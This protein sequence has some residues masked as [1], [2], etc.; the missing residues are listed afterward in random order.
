MTPELLLLYALTIFSVSIVPGPSMAL[1]FGI[2]VRFPIG[3][4]ASAAMGNVSASLLQGLIA[5]LMLK[6][7]LELSPSVF[8]A[9]KLLGALFIG[10]VGVVFIRDA[11]MIARVDEGD[12]AVPTSS[13]KLFA[14]GFVVAFFNPKAIMFFVALFPMFVG[15]DLGAL[16]VAYVF[17]PIG[18]I[19]LGCFLIYCL[20]GKTSVRLLGPGVVA[21]VVQGL[22][23]ILVITSAT[24]VMMT[25]RDLLAAWG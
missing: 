23:A 1:A 21:R 7:I 22:G 13:V 8:E 9:M 20:L 5:L 12:G 25:L 14:T 2:G 24:L 15:G 16:S 4:A 18:L 3:H 6:S 19:A 10:Y 17:A 11:A